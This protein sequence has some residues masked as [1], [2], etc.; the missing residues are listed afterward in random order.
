MTRCVKPVADLTAS[1]TSDGAFVIPSRPPTVAILHP[2]DGTTSAVEQS[3]NLGADAYDV[4]RGSLDG[5]LE[6]GAQL[7]VST[8]SVGTHQIT[9]R[10]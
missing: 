6:N 7:S 8:L 1:D 3:L 2:A 9:V 10:T 5:A 4:D